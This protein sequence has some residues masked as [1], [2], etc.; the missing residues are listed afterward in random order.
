MFLLSLAGPWSSS[1][2]EEGDCALLS[3]FPV[4]TPGISA[5]LVHFFSNLVHAKR[6]GQLFLAFRNRQFQALA[7]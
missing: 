7:P 3:G 4:H 1:R 6:T 2:G 5:L